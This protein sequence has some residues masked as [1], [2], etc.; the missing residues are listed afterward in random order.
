MLYNEERICGLEVD[1]V[2]GAKQEYSSGVHVGS[3]IDELPFI[4]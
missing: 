2:T 4:K 3:T 1:Y